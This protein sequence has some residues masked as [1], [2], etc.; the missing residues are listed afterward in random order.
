MSDNFPPLVESNLIQPSLNKSGI[1]PMNPLDILITSISYE[2]NALENLVNPI[3]KS[4]VVKK[5][6][7]SIGFRIAYFPFKYNKNKSEFIE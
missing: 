1:N 4:P 7:T 2:N 3:K 6:L 5:P